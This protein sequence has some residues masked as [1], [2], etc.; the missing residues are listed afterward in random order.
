MAYTT[1][2]ASSSGSG[3]APTTATYITQTAD[4]TLSAEQA[5]GAL[6]S[7]PL[8]GTTTTGVVSALTTLTGLTSTSSALT[9]NLSTGIA[10]GGTAIGGTLTTQNLTLQPNAADTTT[11][12][13]IALGGK[14]QVGALANPFA[15]TPWIMRSAA[16]N[17]NMALVLIN[18]STGTSAQT[19]FLI[20]NADALNTGSGGF[21][22]NSTGFTTSGNSTAS[23]IVVNLASASGNMIHR[24]TQAAGDHIWETLVA[25]TERVRIPNAGGLVVGPA[26]LSTTATDGFL[27]IPTCAGPPTGVPTTRT[28][29]VALV[30]DTTNHKFYIYDTAWKGGTAPGTWS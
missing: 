11:G 27:Y 21:A 17:N 20:G 13:V 2:P 30:F 26:A 4:A 22:L 5:I 1:I 28:G 23:S 18:P 6:S 24:I 9:V 29:T 14:L 12:A 7:G 15:T 16:T 3:G 19:S 25:N 10:G 8:Y